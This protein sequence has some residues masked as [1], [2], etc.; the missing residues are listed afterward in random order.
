MFCPII[1]KVFIFLIYLAHPIFKPGAYKYPFFCHGA[2]PP[3]Q[4]PQLKLRN[5]LKIH[6]LFGQST[7]LRLFENPFNPNFVEL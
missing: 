3:N 5:P 6:K 4:K 2:S 1:L 7:F